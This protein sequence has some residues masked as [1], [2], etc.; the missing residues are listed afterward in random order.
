M[1]SFMPFAP[2]TRIVTWALS[3][4]MLG[5]EQGGPPLPPPP[6][7]PPVS[8]FPPP[9]PTSPRGGGVLNFLLGIGI[10]LIPLLIAMVGLGGSFNRSVS[11]SQLW[12]ALLYIGG[13][14]YLVQIIVGIVFT[15][16]ERFRLI[17][18]GMLTMLPVSPVVFF[19]GCVAML[20]NSFN[21]GY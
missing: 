18:V 19:I 14:L 10:G 13:A 20:Q 15:V 9:K 8:Q 4:L 17:G 6:N 16:L 7:E 3:R 11:A 21:S 5:F 2:G 12:V 1:P